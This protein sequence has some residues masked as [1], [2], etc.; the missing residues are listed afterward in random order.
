MVTNIPSAD[1]F[2]L[3]GEEL[4]NFAW[5]AVARLIKNLDEAYYY[6]VDKDEVSEQY[7]E[8]A[9]RTLSTSLTVIQQG[10]EFFLKG[11]ISSIS[12]YLLIA[13]SLSKLPNVSSVPA[14]VDFSKF[15]TLDS[16]DLI[17]V[18]NTF[19]DVPLEQ[20]IEERFHNMRERRNSIMHSVTDTTDIQVK[21]VVEYL[22]F[23]YKSF[24]PYKTW[25]ERRVFFLR[26]SPDSE[27]AAEDFAIVAT[28]IEFSEVIK[29][30]SQTEVLK[31]LGVEKKQRT[32]FCPK[33]LDES[34]KNNK[35]ELKLA[36][37]RSKKPDETLLYC[38]ICNLEH[39][40]KRDVCYINNQTSTSD[41][42]P[43]D[44]ISVEYNNCLTCGY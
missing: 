24:F 4:L 7:W 33:C 35:L 12:P 38:P 28:C 43:G 1:E 8:G 36:R 6:G 10:V 22:L 44:V 18:Y 32:Y 34:H 2:Y 41:A 26:Q 15:R 9:N 19:S 23:M 13:D 31:Y 21:E 39:R 17:K 20:G 14:I 16:Q 40:V 29:M 30:L 25:A 3:A 27:L 11:K 5:D 37:L 42:C